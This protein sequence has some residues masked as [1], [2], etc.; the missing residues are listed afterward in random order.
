MPIDVSQLDPE[1]DREWT[2]E[3]TAAFQAHWRRQLWCDH[4]W[5]D[6][7]PGY[8]ACTKCGYVGVREVTREEMG[9]EA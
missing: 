5:P 4:D 7:K 8:V 1:E 6:G 9:E 2:P 3:E